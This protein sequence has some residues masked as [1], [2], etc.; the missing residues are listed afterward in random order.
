MLQKITYL[1]K[2]ELWSLFLACVFPIHL[3]AII[4][5][6]HD[7]EYIIA[8]RNLWYAAGYAGYILA[9]AL[10]ESCLYFL[11]I[12]FLSYLFPQRLKQNGKAFTITCTLSL[13]FPFWAIANQ[14]FYLLIKHPLPF[15]SWIMLRIP[16]HQTLV[17]TTLLLVIIASFVIPVI[18]IHKSNNGQNIVNVLIERIGLLS[19][20]YLI[21]DLLGITASVLRNIG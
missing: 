7:L 15:F 3:W 17:L 16:Y 6:F 1:S 20:F 12:F 11:F 10:F 9:F 5:I 18:V 21:I 14:I 13:I 4:I 2:K 19:I 8:E